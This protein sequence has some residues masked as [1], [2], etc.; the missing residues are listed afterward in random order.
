MSDVHLRGAYDLDD[1]QVGDGGVALLIVDDLVFAIRR[2]RRRAKKILDRLV[3][4]LEE[5]RLHLEAPSLLLHLVRGAEHL[6]DRSGNDALGLIISL[7]RALH[8]KGLTRSGLAVCKDACVVAVEGALHK[9]RHLHK[10]LLLRRGGREHL[11]K[12]IQ[13]LAQTHKHMHRNNAHLE[14]PLAALSL[15]LTQRVL[16]RRGSSFHRA[17]IQEGKRLCRFIGT[18]CRPHTTIHTNV[19]LQLLD[20]VV[21]LATEL[22]VL[23]CLALEFLNALLLLV[24]LDL[25][26]YQK[27]N[28]GN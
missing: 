1:G 22:L 3:V 16:L 24:D 14:V 5:R 23:A 18:L 4:D 15:C 17:I 13:S 7:L 6:L 26:C 27:P 2:L 20:S 19:A 11:V 21:Q 25:K 10:H 12:L 9:L 8:G 28:R